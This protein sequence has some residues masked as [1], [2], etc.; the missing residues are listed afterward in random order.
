MVLTDGGP[1]VAYA[2]DGPSGTVSGTIT[3]G[4]NLGA[5]NTLEGIVNNTHTGVSGP[6]QP[7]Y[8]GISTD[9]THFGMDGFV[10]HGL[11]FSKKTPAKRDS[12]GTRIFQ[13][14]Q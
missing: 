1:L 13:L 14:I 12:A 3:S 11:Y 6:V 7:I 8:S 5:L 9:G 10:S 4:F 2:F